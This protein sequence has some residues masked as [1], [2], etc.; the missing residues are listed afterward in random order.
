MSLSLMMY[1]CI[2]TAIVIMFNNAVVE[3]DGELSDATQT[4]SLC[5]H[6]DEAESY[7]IRHNRIL[8]AHLSRSLNA[9]VRVVR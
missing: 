9:E 7:I 4:F 2:D 5:F 1:V 3:R 8:C 6:S